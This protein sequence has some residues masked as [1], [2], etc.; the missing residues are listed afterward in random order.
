[1]TWSRSD[2]WLRANAP[3][4]HAKLLP[5]ATNLAAVEKAIGAPLPADLAAWWRECGGLELADYAPLIPEFHSPISPDHALEVREFMM[6]IR[7]DVAADVGIEDVEAHEAAELAKPAG[8]RIG[9]LWLP[10]FVP[11]AVEASGSYLFADLREGPRRGCV[12]LFD[13]VEGA[14]EEPYWGSVTEMLDAVVEWLEG[15]FR[16]EWP[17]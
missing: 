13:K 10:L 16:A 8:S 17:A 14:D 3:E 6:P 15:D 12:M 7:R 9:D 11:I 5:P 2:A 1:M 4:L